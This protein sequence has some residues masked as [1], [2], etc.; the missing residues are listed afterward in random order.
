MIKYP[1]VIIQKTA[2]LEE[3]F[4]MFLLGIKLGK[5]VLHPLDIALVFF[6][7]VIACLGDEKESKNFRFRKFGSNLHPA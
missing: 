4:D 6:A 2:D 1:I 5:Q 3:Y 7:L